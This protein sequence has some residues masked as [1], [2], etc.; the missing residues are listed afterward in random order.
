[1]LPP[2]GHRR[3]R[4]GEGGGGGG[5]GERGGGEHSMMHSMMHS[6]APEG[7]WRSRVQRFHVW[8]RR[9]ERQRRR[10]RG[11]RRCMSVHRRRRRCC[12]RRSWRRG[13]ARLPIARSQ[14]LR[15]ELSQPGGRR[16]TRRQ[17]HLRSCTDGTQQREVAL[18]GELAAGGKR[19]LSPRE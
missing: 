17:G 18:R 2:S 11:G 6:M 4:R 3:L 5:G 14:P 7:R 9:W 12:P 10:R 13:G 15:A 19:L 8:W 1:I 16:M